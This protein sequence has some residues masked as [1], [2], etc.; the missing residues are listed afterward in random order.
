MPGIDYAGSEHAD[1]SP[2]ASGGSILAELGAGIAGWGIRKYVG[3]K[4]SQYISSSGRALA[5]GHANYMGQFGAGVHF[6]PMEAAR[7]NA[8]RAGLQAGGI[9]PGGNLAS[10]GRKLTRFSKIFGIATALAFGYD[11]ASSMVGAGVTWKEQKRDSDNNMRES[12][13]APTEDLMGGMNSS[14]AYTQRQRSIQVI[15]NSQMSTRAAFGNEASY[16]HY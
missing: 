6:D 11:I 4:E 14:A 10:V 16:A 12:M 7:K 8:H 13:S 3:P 15:H 5:R 9:K 1:T 2:L